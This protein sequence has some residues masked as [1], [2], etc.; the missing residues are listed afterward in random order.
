[1]LKA[2]SIYF[3]FQIKFWSQSKL[4]RTALMKASINGN[5]EIVKLLLKQK[6]IHVNEKSFCL[7]NLKF[8]FKFYYFQKVF[9]VNLNYF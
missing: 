2:Y 4:F 8:F 6:E 1:M 7:E 9:G 3:M 5:I